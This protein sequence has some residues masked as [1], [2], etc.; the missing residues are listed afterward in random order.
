MVAKHPY[1]LLL[2][3]HFI[4][5]RDIESEPSHTTEKLKSNDKEG[6]MWYVDNIINTA[7]NQ[8]HQYSNTLIVCSLLFGRMLY[9]SCL[10]APLANLEG[11]IAVSDWHTNTLAPGYHLGMW[12]KEIVHSPYPAIERCCGRGVTAIVGPRMYHCC[13]YILP[14]ENGPLQIEGSCAPSLFLSLSSNE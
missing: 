14:V 5:W 2:N 7:S 6:N 10:F 4:T 12:E 13:I 11:R 8:I 1:S 9:S 3:N